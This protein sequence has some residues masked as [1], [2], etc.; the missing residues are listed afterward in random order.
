MLRCWKLYVDACSTLANLIENCTES[1]S[2]WTPSRKVGISDSRYFCYNYFPICKKS[3]FQSWRRGLNRKAAFFKE[4]ALF[5]GRSPNSSARWWV[6]TLL[7][8]AGLQEMYI[9]NMCIIS[10]FQGVLLQR[11]LR[12]ILER[13][14]IL[15][16]HCGHVCTEIRAGAKSSGN[17]EYLTALIASQITN[18]RFQ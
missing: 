4:I 14:S 11:N 10:G 8:S 16:D 15:Y 5:W 1:T 7:Y 13:K 18:S 3:K 6:K 9:K 2:A 17:C 12:R